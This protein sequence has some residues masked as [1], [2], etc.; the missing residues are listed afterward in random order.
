MLGIFI[1]IF[2]IAGFYNTA[3]KK[4]RRGWLWAISAGVTFYGSQFITG[5]LYGIIYSDQITN[6]SLSNHN[7][8][9]I[10]ISLAVSIVLTTALFLYLK[11]S[12][13]DVV[14]ESK[15]KYLKRRKGTTDK[16]YNEKNKDNPFKAPNE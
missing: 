4:G 11:L 15:P 6:E 3:K 8:M 14:S 13:N 1:L 5:M 12:R 16:E 7:M 10:I 2:V 9:A